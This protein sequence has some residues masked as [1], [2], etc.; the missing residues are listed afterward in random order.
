[1]SE[2]R[3]ILL[4]LLPAAL[5]ALA[6]VLLAPAPGWAAPSLA[7]GG[8]PALAAAL[9]VAAAALHRPHGGALL[10]FG[11]LGVPVGWE[12]AAPLPT[13]VAVVAGACAAEALRRPLERRKDAPLPERRGWLRVGER[14]ALAGLGALAGGAL[15]LAAG[16]GAPLA[17]AGA[18]A[19]AASLL[20][21]AL[22]ELSVR[23]LARGERWRAAAGALAP[24]L[25]DLAGFALGLLGVAIL[26]AEPALGAASLAGFALLLLEAARHDLRAE[27]RGRTLAEAEKLTRSSAALAAGGAELE[28][29][30][31][32]IFGECAA[33]A[34]ASLLALELDAPEVGSVRFWAAADGEPRPGEPEPPEFPPALPGFHRRERWRCV[35]HALLASGERRATLRLWCDPRKLEPTAEASLAALLPQIQAAVREA[36]VEREAT[37]DRLTGAATRRALERRLA[38]SFAACRDDGR[39]LAVVMADLDHFKRINDAHGHAA[40]DRALAAVARVLLAPM[41]GRDLCGRYGGEEFALVFE[42]TTGETALEIAERL[43]KRIE[44]LALALPGDGAAPGGRLALSASFGVAAYPALAVR[45]A[46]EL[47]ELADGALYTAKRLG[48]NVALLELGGGLLRT[49]SGEAIELRD[50]SPFRAPVFFA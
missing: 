44:T 4:S 32:R 18:A 27:A 33:T 41:R 23:R 36:L 43:R 12:C 24:L 40:G 49:G 30:A 26:R 19:A 50:D 34:G 28:R 10:G 6:L 31:R 21:A 15:W 35:E 39:P 9:L 25:F 29:L 13:A 17:A 14:A 20:P 8:P 2:T 5:L 16:P 22:F 38:E 3:A 37:I 46:E 45:A 1:V 42:D 48:R 11:A 47:L 7:Q